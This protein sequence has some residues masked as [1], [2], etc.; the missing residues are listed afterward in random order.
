LKQFYT[1]VGVK[2]AVLELRD[3]YFQKAIESLNSIEINE[4][5]KLPL[6]EIV[7]MLKEREV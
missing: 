2:K 5:Q 1:K 7:E 3:L 6:F 4:T